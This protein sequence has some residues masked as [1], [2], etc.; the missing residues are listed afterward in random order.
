[1]GVIGA[2][3]AKNF[4]DF[5]SAALIYFFITMRN[6]TPKTWIEWDRRAFDGITRYL[7]ASLH[8]GL[9]SYLEEVAFLL[10]TMMSMYFKDPTQ[11]V[12]H[13]AIQ[14]SGLFHFNI[15]LGLSFCITNFVGTSLRRGHIKRAK[16]RALMSVITSITFIMICLF[17]LL[18]KKSQWSQLFSDDPVIQKNMEDLVILYAKILSSDGL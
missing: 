13:V 1:M 10:L 9:G 7:I 3:W 5:I 14:N 16:V 4:S 11:T 8:N 2:A 6:P 12:M 17:V 15:F 18:N